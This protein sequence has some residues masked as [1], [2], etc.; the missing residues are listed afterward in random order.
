MTETKVYNPRVKAVLVCKNQ[1]GTLHT[2]LVD[3]SGTI[4]RDGKVDVAVFYIT[5]DSFVDELHSLS[6]GNVFKG[7]EMLYTDATIRLLWEPAPEENLYDP[8]NEWESQSF[9][10]GY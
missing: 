9:F 10:G 8:V 2:R 5:N 3:V 1:D 6:D 4:K 7:N